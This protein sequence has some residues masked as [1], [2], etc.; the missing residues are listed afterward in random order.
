[1]EAHE[2]L[3]ISTP[4]GA[5]PRLPMTGGRRVFDPMRRGSYYAI[6]DWSGPSQGR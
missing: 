4:A 1:V 6:R 5:E 3:L 2:I